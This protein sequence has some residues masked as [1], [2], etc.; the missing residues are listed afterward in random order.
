VAQSVGSK[1]A[2]RS[3]EIHRESAGYQKKNY[4]RKIAE[5]GYFSTMGYTSRTS[6][7]DVFFKQ[8]NMILVAESWT[9]SSRCSSLSEQLS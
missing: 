4:Y 7:E 8:P 1:F 2:A 3:K 6:E 9:L 5:Y